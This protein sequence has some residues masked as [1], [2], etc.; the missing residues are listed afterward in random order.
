MLFHFKVFQQAKQEVVFN[1]KK[2]QEMHFIQHSGYV[3]VYQ[4]T[5]IFS[6]W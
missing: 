4:S 3:I 1:E 6:V 2:S 5:I